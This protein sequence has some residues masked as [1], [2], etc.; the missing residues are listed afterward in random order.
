MDK[1]RLDGNYHS[2]N[3]EGNSLTYGETRALLLFGLTASG[4]PFKDH[5][6]IKGHNEAIQWIEE[7][8]RQERPMNESFIRLLHEVLLKEPYQVDAITP[9]G[10][11]T[12]RWVR[13]GQ[14]KTVPKHVKTVTGAILP[15][16]LHPLLRR[17]QR[18]DGKN[19]DELYPESA[20]GKLS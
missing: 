19:P 1:F 8:L 9:D 5:P 20:N 4:K 17:R 2:D 18:A 14:Y 7:V 11:P 16:Y 3:P 6:D 10:Q 13:I 15:V 12:K